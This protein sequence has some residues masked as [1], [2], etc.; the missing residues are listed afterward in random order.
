[1]LIRKSIYPGV[2]QGKFTDD[3]AFHL[4]LKKDFFGLK[5]DK[6]L[7]FTHASPITSGYTKARSENI[8]DKIETKVDPRLIVFGGLNGKNGRGG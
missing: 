6:N 2:K 4:I 5:F 8:F 7:V 3:D 1:M